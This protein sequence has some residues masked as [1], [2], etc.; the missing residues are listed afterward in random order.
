MTPLAPIPSTSS[1]LP[2]PGGPQRNT[3]RFFLNARVISIF[4]SEIFTVRVSVIVDIRHSFLLTNLLLHIT[5]RRIGCQEKKD[6]K[7]KLISVIS[8]V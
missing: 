4:A 1:D 3:G 6:N 5:V 7:I 2:I 8:H